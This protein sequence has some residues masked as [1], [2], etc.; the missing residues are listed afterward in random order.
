MSETWTDALPLDRL[1]RGSARVAKVG[2]TP[3]AV[4]HLEDGSLYAV[5]N[6]CPHEGYPLVQGLV[7]D[8]TLTCAWH[9]YKFDL[10]DGACLKGDEA[11]RA[12][13]V[14]VQDGVIQLQTLPPDL[15]R[16]R[17]LRQAGL[18]EALF[19]G[20]LGQAL[21]EG[22]RL[23]QLGVRP[24][25]LLAHAAAWDGARGEYGTTHALPVAADLLPTAEALHGPEAIVPIAVVYEL[26]TDSHL[27]R[28][29][30]ALVA[31]VDPGPDP[32]AAGEVFCAHVEAEE[33]AA[34]EAL[35]RGALARGWGR[36][37]LEPWL[38]A[39]CAEHFL[40]FAHGLIYS[41][42]VFDLI[43]ADPA[44][45]EPI[46]TGLVFCLVGDTRDDVLPAWAGWRAR[47][48]ELR[49]RLPD[50]RPRGTVDL[51]PLRLALTDGTPK[52]AFAAL[53]E[54]MEAGA[55]VQSACDALVH[56]AATRLLRFDVA[57]DR[58]PHVQDGWLWVTHLLT[59]ASAVREALQRDKRPDTLR[60]LWQAA[61]VIASARVLDRAERMVLLPAQAPTVPDVFEALLRHDEQTAL[62]GALGLAEAGG[63]PALRVALEQQALR[64]PADL[65]ITVAHVIKTTRVAFIEAARTGE[66]TPVLGVLRLWA[67]PP[68]VR[69]VYQRAME[70][71]NLVVHGQLPKALVP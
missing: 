10:R 7:K 53:T 61:H 4:F 56:G 26:L 30:R 33:G 1:P 8:C 69:R 48:A 51:D 12:W 29:A 63:L 57:I 60:L 65:G 18:E 62:S 32:V 34:A 68:R 14:R 50:L 19:H 2:T 20:R 52:E 25:T 66:L 64:D 71:M 15:P 47:L 23:L 37:E 58:D 43:E 41:T 67:H 11:V 40:G 9:N 59:F 21:R 6:R 70:A 55:T 5:D 38:F 54:A 49:P 3:V 31:P 24:A 13:P 36:T 35:I 46:L 27:R 28:E 39:V 44:H 16:E 17:A 45:A 42:K 22:T